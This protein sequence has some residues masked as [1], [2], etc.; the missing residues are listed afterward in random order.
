MIQTFLK[1]KSPTPRVFVKN[2]QQQLFNTAAIV[3]SDISW[4]KQ[5]IVQT[6]KEILEKWDIHGG[7]WKTTHFFEDLQVSA[8][9]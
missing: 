2:N 4:G 6:L 9:V 1:W 5:E 7:L 8:H 3:S